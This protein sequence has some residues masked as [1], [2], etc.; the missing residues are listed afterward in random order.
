MKDQGQGVPAE[1]AAQLHIFRKRLPLQVCLQETLRSLGSTDGQNCLDIGDDNGMIGYHLRKHGGK[2]SSVVTSPEA[3]ATVK[4][5]LPE[6]AF[7]MEKNTLPFKKKTFDCVVVVCALE[8]FQNDSAFIEECHRVLKPD[9]RL[10]VN[11]ARTKSVSLVNLVRRALGVTL[12]KKGWIRGGY[13]ESELFTILKD[14]FDVHNMRSYSRLFIELVDAVVARLSL[15]RAVED[16]GDPRLK[17]MFSIAGPFYRLAF[18]LDMLLFFSR[19]H[20]LI[21]TAKRRAWSPRKAPILV[22][23]RSITEAV[24]SRP[25]I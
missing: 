2:W 25:G 4:Q 21:A 13:T 11:V 10:V 17:R 12:Q 6:N 23:G 3:L 1:A 24:L 15:G 5:V 20:H 8:R 9:G 22:D 7:L 14:G 19:G 18:Q 16:G